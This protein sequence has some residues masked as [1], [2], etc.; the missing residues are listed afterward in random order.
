VRHWRHGPAAASG[1]G[2]ATDPIGST[3]GGLK[4]Q[5]CLLVAFDAGQAAVVDRPAEAF[6]EDL[7]GLGLGRITL[8]EI[9][10]G[11]EVGRCVAHSRIMADQ[12]AGCQRPALSQ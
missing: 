12:A 7:V 6:F 8:V 11:I 3:L 10:P 1:S 2:P 9:T 5:L 4:D